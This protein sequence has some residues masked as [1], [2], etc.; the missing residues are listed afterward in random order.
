MTS[1]ASSTAARVNPRSEER[2]TARAALSRPGNPLRAALVVADDHLFEASIEGEKSTLSLP[3]AIGRALAALGAVVSEGMP[4]AGTRRVGKDESA[5]VAIAIR[6]AHRLLN[7]VC[8]CPTEVAVAD[9]Q[10]AAVRLLELQFLRLRPTELRRERHG[11]LP[12]APPELAT[13]CTS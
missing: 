2:L 7:G 5:A 4:S 1:A 11:Y 9:R 10:R 12:L 6:D 13:A 8:D 3:A